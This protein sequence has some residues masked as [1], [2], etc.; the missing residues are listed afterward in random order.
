MN[1]FA[2]AVLAALLV[3]VAAS[4]SLFVVN[5]GQFGAVYAMGRLER[6]QREPGLYFKWPAPIENVVLLDRRLRTLRSVQPDAFATR[7]KDDLVASWF[8]KWRIQDPQAYLRSFGT[9]ESAADDRI[10]AALRSQLGSDLAA[11]DLHEVLAGQGGKLESRLAA[12]LGPALRA[13][14]IE[15]VDTGLTELDYTADVTDAV[16]RRMAAARKLVAD[17]TRAQGQAQ[18][19]K[20]R[21]EADRQREVL[22]AQAY[23]KAQTLKGEGDAQAARIYAASFGKDPEFAAFYRSLEAY[24]ASFHS[25]RDVMVL[26]PSSDFFRFMRSPGGK[27]GPG[28]APKR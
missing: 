28:G 25:R 17:Q 4:S 5:R 11:L 6:V 7:G 23:R 13:S 16:Y 1:R 8:V 14:G 2:L 15:V 26:D 19:D 18:A 9:G 21:A 24:R 22:L 27:P 3:L 12:Q 20:I 10:G